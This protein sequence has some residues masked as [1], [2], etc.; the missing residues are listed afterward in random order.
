MSDAKVVPITEHPLVKAVLSRMRVT[1]VVATRSV[2]GPQGDHYVGFS[3]AFSSVQEDAA[4]AASLVGTLND[5]EVHLSESAHGLTMKEAK[6]AAIILGVQA[7]RAA[8]Q[9]AWAGGNMS[10]EH[11]L[12]AL[13]LINTNYGRLILEAIGEDPQAAEPSSGS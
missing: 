6:L 4:G 10:K 11:R 7:D 1:K 8:H 2:K 9:N 3:A 12:A 5:A 13:S